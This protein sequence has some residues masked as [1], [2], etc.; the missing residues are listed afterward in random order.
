[1]PHLLA[2]G[3]E[4]HGFFSSC[5]QEEEREDRVLELQVGAEVYDRAYK[6]DRP[7]PSQLLTGDV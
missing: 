7:V 2:T 4:V 1:P 5:E 6:D 3:T